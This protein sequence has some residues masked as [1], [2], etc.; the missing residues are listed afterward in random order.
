[1]R[2]KDV[3]NEARDT[4]PYQLTVDLYDNA[5]P[6]IKEFLQNFHV[7]PN[8]DMFWSGRA[9]N[10]IVQVKRVRKNREPKDTEYNI[11]HTI[12]GMFDRYH[13]VKYRS[14]A[15]FVTG[16]YSDADSYGDDVYSIFPIGA[17]YKYVFHPK[18]RDLF[19]D[20]LDNGDNPYLGMDVEDIFQYLMDGGGENDLYDARDE[21][22]E[23][24]D[25]DE[26]DYLDDEGEFDEGAYE[27]AREAFIDSKA[28]ELYEEKLRN[29]AEDYAD[30]S[31]DDLEGYISDYQDN[32]LRDA[33]NYE[34]EVMLNCDKYIMVRSDYIPFVLRYMEVN[35]SR[36]PTPELWKM[37]MAKFDPKMVNRR[38]NSGD[39]TKAF[40]RHTRDGSLSLDG[41]TK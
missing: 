41:L 22:Y 23:M 4:D 30:Q 35:A 29:R 24:F 14:N 6:F 1:M 28:D 40:Q 20:L 36:K 13:G 5:F 16:K 19:S 34:V 15:I 12:D 3:L 32:P 7:T 8:S 17:N 37:A 10:K 38:P 26:D 9:S 11:H 27:D 25:E 2:F 33:I 18:I 31:T 39:F 21:A